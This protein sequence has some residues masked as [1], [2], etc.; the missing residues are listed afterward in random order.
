LVVNCGE[1]AVLFRNDGG[2]Q[3]N[4]LK[5]LTIGKTSNRN[6][7]GARMELT[8]GKSRQIREVISGSSYLSQ[9]SLEVE[10]G[11]GQIDKIER[12]QILWPSGFKQNLTNVDVNQ[13]LVF[14][15]PDN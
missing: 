6:G 10:F 1:E 4:W 14:T 13:K 9:S 7:I 3:N 5:V 8:A 2:N 11:L 15:E 12:I